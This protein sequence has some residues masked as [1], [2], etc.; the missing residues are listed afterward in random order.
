MII[1]HY[2]RV[3]NP[4]LQTIN[5]SASSERKV[6]LIFDGCLS[7][8]NIDLLKDMGEDG[9]VVLIRMKN[10]SHETNME[11]LVNLVS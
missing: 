1:E 2:H 9:M 7:E 10:T 5:V 8:L 11:D 6:L 3:L 4:W